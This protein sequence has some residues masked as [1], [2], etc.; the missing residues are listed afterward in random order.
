VPKEA[1]EEAGGEGNKVSVLSPLAIGLIVALLAIVAL[2]LNL[3]VASVE[4]AKVLRKRFVTL[5]ALAL[6]IPFVMVATVDKLSQPTA[7]YLASWL[8]E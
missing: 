2:F 4:D 5:M 7:T 3:L 8:Q 1:T 6:A